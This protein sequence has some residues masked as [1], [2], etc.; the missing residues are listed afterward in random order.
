MRSVG[1]NMSQIEKIKNLSVL[2]LKLK[3]DVE[4]CNQDKVVLLGGHFPLLY[5][6]NFDIATEAISYWGHF[7]PFTL[8]LAC[9]VAESAVRLGKK[10]EFVFFVDDHSY[11]GLSGLSPNAR[12]RR[13]DSLYC[14]RNGE[15]AVLPDEYKKI[16]NKYGFSEANVVRH[17][18]GKDG[19]HECLYFSE[20]RLRAS[21]RNIDNACARE[22]VA[23]LE[24]PKYFNKQRSYI[25]AVVPNRCKG[26]ICDI[27]L[28]RELENIH[29]SHVFF[30]TLTGVSRKELFE[31][32]VGVTYRKD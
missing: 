5:A 7:S 1:K 9:K 14:L 27:A 2:L 32:G 8:E 29:A 22:Y 16:L 20:K 15:K 3:E 26:H 10:V 4:K 11:E 28:D 23:F 25:I 30:D 24:N 17:D 6:R 18:H 21:T 19:R 12:S 13:R 31:N